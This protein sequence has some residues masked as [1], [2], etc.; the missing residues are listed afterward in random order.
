MVANKV[1]SDSDLTVYKSYLSFT[2][3]KNTHLFSTSKAVV[4]KSNNLW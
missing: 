2:H 4:W 3:S 1:N